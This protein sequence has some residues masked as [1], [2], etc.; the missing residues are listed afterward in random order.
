MEPPATLHPAFLDE[1]VSPGKVTALGFHFLLSTS[2]EHP[3]P[4]LN[5]LEPPQPRQEREREGDQTWAGWL[6]EDAICE[7]M[8]QVYSEA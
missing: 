1:P 7:Y 6:A 5:H 4:P 8:R 2:L 3:A